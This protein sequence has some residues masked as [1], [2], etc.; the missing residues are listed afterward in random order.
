MTTVRVAVTGRETH[1]VEVPDGAEWSVAKVLAEAGVVVETGLSV[2][3][4]GNVV[5][6]AEKVIVT[7]QNPI[8]LVNPR[9]NNG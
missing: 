2:S 4:Q 6:D 1:N 5:K 3:L 9:V 8:I 7:G